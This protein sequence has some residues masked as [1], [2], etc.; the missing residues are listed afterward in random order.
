[1]RMGRKALAALVFAGCGA[2]EDASKRAR[3]AAP[4]PTVVV[5]DVKTEDVPVIREFVART[6]AVE[7]ISIQARVEAILEKRAFEEGLPV[8]RGQVLYEL[9]KRTYEANLSTAEAALA[10]AKS[11]LKLADEQVS[12]RAGLC[13]GSC[14]TA[15]SAA[16]G[17]APRARPRRARKWAQ[18][19]SWPR[20]QRS[21]PESGAWPRGC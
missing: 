15:H 20:R 12:V 10:K 7:T 18:A 1:M 3:G 4:T 16:A 17:R 9:D 2:D 19:A 8:S 5:A 21:R 11:D 6:E 14:S 13:T